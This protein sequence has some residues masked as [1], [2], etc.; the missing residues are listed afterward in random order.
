MLYKGANLSLN[1]F[2]RYSSKKTRE[3][4]ERSTEH[5]VKPYEKQDSKITRMS[6]D[7]KLSSVFGTVLEEPITMFFNLL[8]ESQGKIRGKNRLTKKYFIS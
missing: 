7:K 1:Q 2:K 4:I 3:M 8:M 6:S 5:K